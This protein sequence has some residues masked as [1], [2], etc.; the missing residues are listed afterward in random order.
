M[1]EDKKFIKD[2][3]EKFKNL[4]KKFSKEIVIQIKSRNLRNDKLNNDKPFSTNQA[5]EKL[6]GIK[7]GW[8]VTTFR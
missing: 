6:L 1:D 7:Q 4:E 5:E 2:L 3:D 8:R